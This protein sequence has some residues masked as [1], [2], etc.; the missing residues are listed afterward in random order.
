MID[1]STASWTLHSSVDERQWPATV[2]GCVHTDLLNAEV[3][4]DPWY[5]D[6]EKDI[7]WVFKQDWVYRSTIQ[8]DQATLAQSHAWLVCE[9]LDTLCTL[10]INGTVVL[11]ADN[12]H[13]TWVVSVLGALRAG[14]ND[15]E[16]TF[17]SPLDRMNAG[18]AERSLPCWNLY[19]TDFIGK[20][21]VRKM[22]CAF[23]WDWGVMAPTAGIWRAMG[24]E[25]GPARLEHVRV[26][27]HHGDRQ[28][29]LDVQTLLA[30][31]APAVRHRLSL[32]GTM[33]AEAT[34]ADASLQVA[35]PQLWWSNG[36]GSQPLYTLTT[37]IVT[38]DGEL[39]DSLSKKIGL[40]TCELIQEDDEFGRSFRFRVNGRDVFMKG[41]NWIPCDV[42]PSRIADETYRH[43]V[44]SSAESGMNMIRVWGGGIYEDER[45]YDLCDEYGILIWQ[46]FMF[47]CSTYPCSDTAFQESVRAEAIDNVRRLH[48]RACLALWC[49]NNELEQ[50]LV[51]GDEWTDRSMPWDEYKPVFDELLPEVVGA[52]DGVTPYWPSSAH[53]PIG[54]RDNH[55]D[56]RSGDAHAWSVW[57]GGQPIESQRDWVFRF[58]SEFG[59]QSFPEPKTVEAFTAP[60]DRSLT[61]WVMDCHQRSTGGNQKIYRTLLD[62][63]QPPT[64]FNE[65]LWV[66]QIVQALCI[67]YAAEHAR[68]IQGRM[69][70]LL[71][72]QLNDLWPGATWSSIDVYGRWK[73]LQYLAKR[74]FAPVLISLLEQYDDGTVA[75]H[76]SNHRP[77]SFTGTVRWE[78]TNC[79]GTVFDRG[80]LVVAVGSQEN[81]EL[82]T[83][84]C[85]QFREQ[86]G[87]ARLPISCMPFEIHDATWIPM[88]GDQDLLVWAILE[89]DGIEIGRNLAFFTKPKYWKLQTPDI[90][91]QVIETDDGLAVE[92]QTDVCSPW[93]RLEIAE[94]EARFADNFVHLSPSFP[95]RIPLQHADGL[96]AARL[97]QRVSATPLLK[98]WS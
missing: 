22:A 56:H 51:R 21:Y 3:I 93:T 33:V 44:A 38:A 26:Q 52:E 61:N 78:I 57:F 31:E 12:M 36:M 45:F 62:W 17:H 18:D 65:G 70:G 89:E 10:R 79:A 64:D 58:M 75:V 5:R 35:D 74:F 80:S 95:C 94:S 28:V 81:V 97:A 6:N 66:T 92:L 16:V 60:E 40:R 54:D 29:R 50:G 82:G 55:N 77:E 87:A 9:G 20:S 49:G 73:A 11:E 86:G 84:A 37:E 14:A 30:G 88:A 13:R 4:P 24:I 46:D 83:I 32:N 91:C 90:T 34:G 47:A 68:R 8:V 48:H 25:A 98:S 2:P 72:W 1:L 59:F 41:A 71:Y 69:D 39:I 63:F 76:V 27:Q 42:F 23:G 85:Q 19:H 43:L 53:T 7:H 96:D 67:Q 15:I